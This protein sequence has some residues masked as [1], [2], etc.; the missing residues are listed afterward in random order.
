MSSV[1]ILTPNDN[2]TVNFSYQP[3]DISWIMTSSAL[4]WLMSP[5]V[6]LFYSGLTK[7]K[8]ALS[9]IMLSLA[10]SAVVSIQWLLLGYSLTF[11]SNGN[12]FIGSLDKALFFHVWDEPSVGS[13]KIPDLVYSIYQGMFAMPIGPGIHLD[14][15]AP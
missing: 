8:N 12:F 6:G 4:V 13:K 11:S 1:P 7:S 5:G 9:L 15:Q 14:G 2:S 3:G 10:A